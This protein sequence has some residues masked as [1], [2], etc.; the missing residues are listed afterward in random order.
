METPGILLLSSLFFITNTAT[1]LFN[2]YY[3]YS[4]LFFILTIT[5]LV[6]HYND[7]IYTNTIDKI[8]VSSIVVYGGY[9]AYSKINTDKW[10]NFIAI[11]VTFLLCIY[12]YI[13]FNTK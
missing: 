7:N 8:A 9:M 2:E 12:L 4:F 10:L 11:T 6:V 13:F 5:S 1:A 3:V